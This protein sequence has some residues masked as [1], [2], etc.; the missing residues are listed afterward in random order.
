MK[1]SEVREEVA[2]IVKAVKE[3]DAEV[4]LMSQGMR[5]A[6]IYIVIVHVILAAN[7]GCFLTSNV[8]FDVGYFGGMVVASL[9]ANVMLG[10]FIYSYYTQY[11][12]IPEA[13]RKQSKL[14]A[15][16]RGKVSHYA[17]FH[18]GVLLTA[19]AL[20]LTSGWA[21]S[22]PWLQVPLLFFTG[23]AL[24]F[25]LGRFNLPSLAGLVDAAKDEFKNKEL[26]DF[27]AENKKEGA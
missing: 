22:L 10:V 12:F 19:S 18:F 6:V 2:M 1:Q 5:P 23:F 20:G 4:P 9:I 3:S 16:I 11:L 15:L 8:R 27:L 24:L 21:A 26:Q 7:I 17:Y 13:T 14:L 25:E